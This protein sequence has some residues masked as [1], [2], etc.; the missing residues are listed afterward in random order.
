MTD[1]EYQNALSNFEYEHCGC[2][3]CRKNSSMSLWEIL[4]GN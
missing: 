2:D 4:F 1:E 3:E